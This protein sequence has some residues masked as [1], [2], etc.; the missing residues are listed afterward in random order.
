MRAYVHQRAAFLGV[1]KK[2]SKFIEALW[3][4]IFYSV[5]VG[6]GVYCLL[7]PVMPDYIR[8]NNL[9]S[10]WPHTYANEAVKMYF[11]MEM[12]AYLHQLMWTEVSRSDSTE[13]IIHH[14]VTITLLFGSYFYNFTKM[15]SVIILIHDFSDIFLEAAKI[16]SYVQKGRNLAW[17][18]SICD[19]L[20][21]IF[22]ISFFL[23]RLVVYPR[24]CVYSY[25]TEYREMFG[26]EHTLF[27]VFGG[28]VLVLQCLHLF[29]FSIIA[30]MVYIMFATDQCTEDLRSDDEEVVDEA[31][32]AT[33][34][35]KANTRSTVGSD[36]KKQK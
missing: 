21:A 11:Q 24:Y 36:S 30:K 22:G 19:V 20:F 10:G 17:M 28:L 3:R 31:G 25:F 4:L 14:V 13:M 1:D 35:R 9:W 6:V 26:T 2:V 7:W 27:W 32:N 15:G 8:E 23:A 33:S 12:G 18:A 29:W 34:S 16:A 5:F